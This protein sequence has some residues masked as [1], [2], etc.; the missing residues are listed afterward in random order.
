VAFGLATTLA[1]PHCDST[2]LRG[3]TSAGYEEL[4]P[5][6]DSYMKNPA[7][8]KGDEFIMM[9]HWFAHKY[10]S[11][12]IVEEYRCIPVCPLFD[13]WAVADDAWVAEIGG[14]P[15]PDWTKF[16]GFTSV[17]EFSCPS[18]TS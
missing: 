16:F 1:I 12:D 4:P 14:I 10:S 7:C 8:P 18:L 6:L 17:R 5:L 15:C 13:W 9:L 2:C 3:A 11:R